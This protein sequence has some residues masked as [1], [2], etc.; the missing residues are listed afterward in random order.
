MAKQKK[1]KKK[2]TN[3]KELFT[4]TEVLVITV[5]SIVFGWFMGTIVNTKSASQKDSKEMQKFH[6]VYN[7]IVSNYYKEVDKKELVEASINGMLDYLDDPYTSY[8][9]EKETESF[10]QIMGGEY[11]GVGISIAKYKED[12]SI[13]GVFKNSPASQVGVKIGDIIIEVNEKSMKNKEPDDVVKIVKKQKKI[14][15]KIK[16][17]DE[18]KTFTM[19]TTKV[20]LPSVS[21]KIIEK[22]DKKVGVIS[23]SLFAANTSTQFKQELKELENKKIDSYIIDLRGNY[24][25]Y[26]SEATNII[27]EFMDSTHV[28]YQIKNSSKTTKYY[29]HG[30]TTKKYNVVILIDE[31]SA[32]ASEV[33][34]AAFKDSYNSEV[35][36]K[37]SYGKG[38]VQQTADLKGGGSIKFTTETWLTPKGAFINGNGIEPTVEVDLEEDYYDNPIDEND[39]QLQKALEVITKK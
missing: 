8:M 30:K 36:G 34:A 26:L 32:S 39:T 15:L 22:D 7:T 6:D 21:S 38:T 11:K 4:M 2:K 28:I 24:G 10:N 1:K 33:V 17:D 12:I 23:I 14:K 9:N 35:V 5:L 19:E 18:E 3:K 25:G 16:R 13:T 29:A 27:S 31:N 37:K 20:I